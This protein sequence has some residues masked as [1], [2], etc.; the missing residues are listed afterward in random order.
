MTAAPAQS[1]QIL[2]IDDHLLFAET[3]KS[4]LSANAN[5]ELCQQ[6]MQGLQAIKRQRFDL[7]LLDINLPDVD[8]C[9]LLKLIQK[10]DQP[11]P[12]LMLSGTEDRQLIQRAQASGAGGFCHKSISPD[13]LGE[14]VSAV[15]AGQPWWADLPA[16]RDNTEAQLLLAQQLGITQRQHQVLSLLDQ[17]MYNKLIADE[18]NIS[19][20]T[21]KTHI[22]AIYQLLDAHNR[23]T[24]L[25]NARQLGLLNS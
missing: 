24:C 13:A 9:S 21:V 25:H 5:V 23:T 14:A 19:E 10:L 1:L 6:G 7:V 3:L 12:V 15:I 11:P 18:L 16:S 4:L 22:A 17:G 20:A 8:G 2:L